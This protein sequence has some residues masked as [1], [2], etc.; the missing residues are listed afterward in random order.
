MRR[1]GVYIIVIA[2]LIASIALLATNSGASGSHLSSVPI[3]EELV[4]QLEAKGQLGTNEIV[5]AIERLQAEREISLDEVSQIFQILYAKGQRSFPG[6][7][8]SRGAERELTPSELADIAKKTE[9]KAQAGIMLDETSSGAS[10]TGYPVSQ[11]VVI[12]MTVQ[13]PASGEIARIIEANRGYLDDIARLFGANAAREVQNQMIKDYL[14]TLSRLPAEGK[15]V[16]VSLVRLDPAQSAKYLSIEDI[17]EL[18][19]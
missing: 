10:P 9:S 13:K 11:T 12:R 16:E 7:L 4:Q 18:T 1:L 5:D 14:E 3:V 19:P 15:E 8:V 17:E 2:L 6:I